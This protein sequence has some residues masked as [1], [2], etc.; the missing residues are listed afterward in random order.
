M[1]HIVN[2]AILRQRIIELQAIIRALQEKNNI[3]KK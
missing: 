2:G 1:I 3:K